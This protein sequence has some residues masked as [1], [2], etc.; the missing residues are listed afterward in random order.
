[1]GVASRRRP[2]VASRGSREIGMQEYGPKLGNWGLTPLHLF[3]VTS[4]NSIAL[5]ADYVT[6]VVDIIRSHAEYPLPLIFLAKADPCSSRSRTV[7]L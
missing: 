4:P 6:V 7:S 2:S 5:Q 1:M 3:C